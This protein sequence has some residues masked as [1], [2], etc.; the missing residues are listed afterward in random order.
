MTYSA[1]F[2]VLFEYSDVIAK[3]VVAQIMDIISRDLYALFSLKF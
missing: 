1:G 2:V 3:Y